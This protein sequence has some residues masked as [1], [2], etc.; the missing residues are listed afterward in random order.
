VL[1]TGRTDLPQDENLTVLSVL[2]SGNAIADAVIEIVA[3]QRIVAE[4]Q[5]AAGLTNITFRYR[6]TDTKLKPWSPTEL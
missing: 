6:Q 4:M 2:G 1:I 5:D 3:A